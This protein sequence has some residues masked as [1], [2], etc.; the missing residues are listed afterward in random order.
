MSSLFRRISCVVVVATAFTA[1]D[2]V[3]V[4]RSLRF[5]SNAAGVCQAALPAFE[6]LIRKRPMAVQNEGASTAFVTCSPVTLQGLPTG[7]SHLVWLVNNTAVAVT[8]TC[9]GVVGGQNG[10][11]VLS[12]PKTTVVPPNSNG[13]L[14]WG[15]ADLPADDNALSFNTSCAL[16]PGTGIATV[17]TR[18]SLDVGQ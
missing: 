17:Y 8:I 4:D 14:I 5:Q 1:G 7:G 9:T 2:A 13:V 12:L 11:A 18:Q 6:G 10:V 3:A 16:A 15:A